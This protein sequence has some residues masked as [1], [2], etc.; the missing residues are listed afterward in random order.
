MGKFSET[1]KRIA[2]YFKINE[3]N[4]DIGTTFNGSYI[5]KNQGSRLNRFN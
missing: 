3:N 1:C 5:D 2:K 4:S